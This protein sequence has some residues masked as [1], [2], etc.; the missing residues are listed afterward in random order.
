VY[1]KNQNKKKTCIFYFDIIKYGY[2]DD[3]E[4]NDDKIT[5]LR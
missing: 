4:D 5:R 1:F 2:D 3:D